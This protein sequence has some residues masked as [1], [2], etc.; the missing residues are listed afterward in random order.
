[1]R[2]PAVDAIKARHASLWTDP[3]PVYWPNENPVLDQDEAGNVVAFLSVEIVGGMARPVERGNPGHNLHRQS[4]EIIARVFVPQGTGEDAARTLADAF[5]ANFIECVFS[6]VHC[7]QSSSPTG[8]R[9]SDE[10]GPYWQVDV[11]IPFTFDFYA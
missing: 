7:D 10:F 2:K 4:G 1:M 5:A 3:T 6:G 11:I 8:G 9:A